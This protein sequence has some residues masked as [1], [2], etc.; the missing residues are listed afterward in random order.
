VIARQETA[1]NQ[2]GEGVRC[3][4]DDRTIRFQPET[5]GCKSIVKAGLLTRPVYR[6]FPV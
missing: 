3:D 2:I 4:N 1:E 5:R 6:A